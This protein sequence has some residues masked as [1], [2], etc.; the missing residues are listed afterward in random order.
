MQR[1]CKICQTNS[2]EVNKTQCNCDYDI[3]ARE[4]KKRDE[5]YRARRM[6]IIQK[7]KNLE[8]EKVRLR[9]EYEALN[10]SIHELTLE[11]ERN[12]PR[13]LGISLDEEIPPPPYES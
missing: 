10:Q 9:T 7:P 13:G 5:E 11:L 3:N 6:K 8:A 12:P 1:V 2:L 4:V